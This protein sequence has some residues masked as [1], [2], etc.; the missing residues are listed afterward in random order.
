[1]FEAML[2][3]DAV[4]SRKF[5]MNGI[6]FRPITLISASQQDP[7]LLKMHAPQNEKP[8]VA[9]RVAGSDPVAH[10]NQIEKPGAHACFASMGTRR[11]F[12]A[13]VGK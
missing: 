2:N 7:I 10:P 6:H 4:S 11:Q 1:M 3:Y 8:A 12:H 9:P 13:L 5:C